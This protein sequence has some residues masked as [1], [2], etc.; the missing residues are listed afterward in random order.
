MNLVT[1]NDIV[2]HRIVDVIISM[3]DNPLSMSD[4]SESKG[5]LR[6]DNGLVI[7]FDGGAPLQLIEPLALSDLR[8]DH[9]SEAE[10]VTVV[11]EK[12][13][14]VVH[15]GSLVYI[16][17]KDGVSV[18]TAISQFWVRPC[19]DRNLAHLAEAKSIW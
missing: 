9:E 17:V 4:M 6:L 8:R 13:V 7:H 11:G 2:G 1:R 12:I 15:D 16:L 10:F 18:S 3:P 5:Y 19:L 14:D